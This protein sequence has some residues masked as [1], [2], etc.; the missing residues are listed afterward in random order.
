MDETLDFAAVS[1]EHGDDEA[2]IADGHL[3]I[4]R[5]PALV[6]GTGELA[7]Y[8]DI[9]VVALLGH[10]PPNVQQRIRGIVVD[11]SLIVNNLVK[12]LG[13]RG[14]EVDA[15]GQL[16]K[17]GVAHCVVAQQEAQALLDGVQ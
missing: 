13:D 4:L 17:H 15:H 3:G 12:V 5:S 11:F 1:V 8:L 16:G 7:A 6:L 9:Y 14:I 2:S 10:L